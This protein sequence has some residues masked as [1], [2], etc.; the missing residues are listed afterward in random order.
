[1][2]ACATVPD[3]QPQFREE[4]RREFAYQTKRLR[5]H[6][7]L[8]LFCGSNEVHWLFNH[9]DNPRWG[10]EFTYEHPY[11][12]YL[13]NI[14]AKEILHANCPSIVYWN[15]SPYGG[16]LPNSDETG[17]IHHWNTAFMSKK[18]EERI[19]PKDY[20]RI[21]AKFVSEYGFVGPCCKETTEEYLD[22]QP[23]DCAGKLWWW[24]SNVFEKGTV[25]TA[26]EKNYMDHAEELSL[27]D[28]ITYG[29]LV[30]GLM[31]G[32]S[33]EAMRFKEHCYGGL[34]WMYN[35]A[36][37]EVGWTIIDY[38]LRR[39]IPFYAVKRALAH[40]KFT[41]RVTD[42]MLVLQGCNDLPEPMNVTAKLGYVSFDGKQKELQEISLHVNPGERTYLVEQLLPERDYTKGTIALYVDD[43]N[44]S[45]VWLRMDDMRTL[46]IPESVV[47]CVEDRQEGN[48]RIIKVASDTFSHGVHVKGNFKC[49][50]NYFDLLPGEEKTI[51]VKDAGDGA[52][53]IE[54]VR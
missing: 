5:N 1:M 39:K 8:G 38:Y 15:S 21:K 28:Y 48:D 31:Y 27:E 33:L 14:M 13:M 22:G 30:H 29:G 34:I 44:I 51:V 46:E 6:C 17:D 18:M 40:Q 4:I 19:E 2:F 53:E 32:Y 54:A 52:L 45:N 43:E 35:D 24:H 37:G 49:S 41:M 50:D 23:A 9:I 7:S 47:R 3:H 42:K 36:W 20:D 11:G 16:A 10:I 12:M 26:I 25:H